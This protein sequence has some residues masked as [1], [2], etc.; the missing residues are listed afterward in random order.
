MVAVA[1]SVV[2]GRIVGFYT[3]VA[4]CTGGTDVIGEGGFAI[5]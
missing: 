4:F 3:G 5:P 2:I 1:R